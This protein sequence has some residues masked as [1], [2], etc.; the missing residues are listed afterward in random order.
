ML[1]ALLGLYFAG[2]A[3]ATVAQ[4]ADS[5]WS[6]ALLGQ[7]TLLSRYYPG[8]NPAGLYR[9]QGEARAE[10]EGEVAY[11]KYWKG[12]AVVIANAN[13]EEGRRNRL[14]ANEAYVYY[15]R[16][17]YFLKAGKQTVKWGALTGFSAMDLANRYDYYDVLDTEAERLG[18]WGLEARYSKGRTELMLRAFHPDNRSRLYLE[19]NRWVNLPQRMP[20]PGGEAVMAY[21]GAAAHYQKRRP[22]LSGSLSTEVGRV[23]V[24][25]SW[26]Y[27]NNDIPLSRIQ[28]MAPMG[29][30]VPYQVQLHFEP[31]MISALNLST[32]AGEWNL[33]AEGAYVSSK[34]I[35]ESGDISPD[36]YTFCSLGADRFW[37]FEHPERQLRLV[38]QYLQVF[39][40]QGG[41]YAPTE[42]DH[43]F[44]SAVLMDTELQINYNWSAALRAVGEFRAKGFYLE[45]RLICKAW[46]PLRAE[47]SGS[48]LG[49]SGQSFFGHFKSNSRVA[50]HLIRP[51]L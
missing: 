8:Q 17:H 7:A 3:A 34:R 11:G 16:G 35:G 40:H 37:A 14:W 48:W 38:A 25:G 51:I 19:D 9:W 49:G 50:L 33:W 10:L 44:Q 18:L 5:D 22:F 2:F 36:R 32:W 27:G 43:I 15:R 13:P 28:V 1:K 26:L 42:I 30:P 45:P 31:L 24:R 12:R 29:S 41:R 21:E 39:P 4:E 46:A 20:V 6:T 47:L 23:Q